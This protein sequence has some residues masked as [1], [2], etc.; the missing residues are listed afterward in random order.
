MICKFASFNSSSDLDML[1]EVLM[2][3]T[4]SLGND[5]G[6]QDGQEQSSITGKRKRECTSVLGVG[7]HYKTLPPSLTPAVAGL[8]S[9]EVFLVPSQE[10]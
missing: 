1:T 7:H 10:K 8:L 6:C 5:V 4:I 2:R 3:L 9:L